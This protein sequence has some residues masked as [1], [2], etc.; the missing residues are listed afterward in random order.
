[1][2][3]PFFFVGLRKYVVGDIVTVTVVHDGKE[4]TMSITLED[5]PQES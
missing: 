2:K 5:R 4:K 1:M 3:L